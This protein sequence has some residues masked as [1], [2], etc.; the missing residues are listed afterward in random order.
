M[1]T[2]VHGVLIAA[3]LLP[4]CGAQAETMAER[5]QRI[6]RK[7]LRERQNVEHSDIALPVAE[8]DERVIN[9]E[10]YRNPE[11]MLNQNS[12]SPNALPMV[13]PAVIQSAQSDTSWAL[14]DDGD[15]ADLYADPFAMNSGSTDTTTSRDD[16]WAAW[17]ERQQEARD[18][19]NSG[20]TTESPYAPQTGAY[21]YSRGRS[22]QTETTTSGRYG[23][24]SSTYGSTGYNNTANPNGLTTMWSSS[25]T[26]SE[27]PTT[28][29]SSRTQRYTPYQNPYQTQSS[30]ATPSTQQQNEYQSPYQQWRKNNQN[31][32]PSADTAPMQNTRR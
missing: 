27:T 29:P 12:S 5:K 26:S 4:L 21:P 1:K 13:R 28:V 18:R 9:S 31:W 3:A 2:I 16:R 7:Y 11:S 25:T 14:Q 32:N 22:S 8:E 15:A 6:M 23:R 30:S 24:S 17:S 19:Y 10:K 20:Y